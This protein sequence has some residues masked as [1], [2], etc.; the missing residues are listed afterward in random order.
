MQ[1]VDV[2]I[3]GGG[4]AGLSAGISLAG[5]GCQVLVLERSGSVPSGPGETLHPGAEAIFNSLGVHEAML[6]AA[7]ARHEEILIHNN[8]KTVH[9]PYGPG[10]RGFQIRR[11][12]L[13][14][15]L[16]DQ[17]VFLG[18]EI[19]FAAPAIDLCREGSTYLV[20]TANG[21]VGARW[22]IDASGYSGWLDRYLQASMAQASERIWL[23]Y[24]YRPA[25]V[26]DNVSPSLSVHDR[27]WHWQAPLGDGEA[28]WVCGT[29]KVPNKGDDGSKLI[30]GTWRLSE[31]PAGPNY[32][33][34][35]DAVCRLDPRNGHGVLRA[36][37][38]ALMATHLL[39]ASATGEVE[40]HTAVEIYS[41]WIAH[42]F[43]FDAAQLAK[44]ERKHLTVAS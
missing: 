19:Q 26:A 3:V 2:L 41:Q 18:G 11:S 44:L 22:L 28:A 9:V 12:L 32:F 24:G 17:F 16:A 10:W 15:A 6:N 43:R 20:E 42:W 37:M 23:E 25:G 29:L 31:C 30:D 38:S 1:T 39:K 5:E 4:P 8:N 35:G 21:A 7:T 14:Q 36:M 33:R 27:S 34:I 13:N 40:A